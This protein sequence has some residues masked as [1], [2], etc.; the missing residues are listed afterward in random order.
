MKRVLVSDT[1]PAQGLEILNAAEGVQVD[2]NT[3]LKPDQ[4]KAIIGDYDALVVRSA[5]KVTAEIIDAAT[6]L[7]VIGRAGIGVDNVDVT[8]ATKRGIVVM[9]TPAGNIVTTAEHAV[10]L[11]M[12]LVRMVP[13]AT[14]SM[15]QGAWEK[16]KFQG[17]ELCGKT[18]G[19]V[20]LGN[21]GSIVADRALGLK[22]KVAAYDP[23]ISAEHAAKMGVELVSLDDLY[24]RSDIISI[25]VPLVA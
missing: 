5:T 3:G 20:G 22:M 25:H 10:A 14:M 24:Q 17:R 15:K 23:F 9:N 8:A 4:L 12:S 7:K 21:I 16:K 19:V 11:M 2:V 1:L 18:L 6:N 13:Q